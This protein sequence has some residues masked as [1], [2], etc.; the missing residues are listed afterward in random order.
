[1]S[2][3][4][5]AD[6]YYDFVDLYVSI[7]S[8]DLNIANASYSALPLYSGPQVTIR[9]G[10]SHEYKLSK[11][12]LCKHSPYFEATFNGNF[13]EGKELSTTLKEEDGVVSKQSFELLIQWMYLGQV[14][15]GDMDPGDQVTAAI[16]FSRMADL[17][18][19][20]G[21]EDLMAEHVRTTILASSPPYSY[22]LQMSSQG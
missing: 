10:S 4:V 3:A 19:I 9:V 21:M 2:K 16:E 11:D 18:G 14:I 17:C 6:P 1:M 5:L 8:D 22:L 7:E 20:T 12:L 13:R 15:F